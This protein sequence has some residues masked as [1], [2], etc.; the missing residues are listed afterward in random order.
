MY[1]YIKKLEQK[2]ESLQGEIEYFKDAMKEKEDEIWHLET[3]LREV[4]STYNDLFDENEKL[5]SSNYTMDNVI[6]WFNSPFVSD[7]DKAK[8]MEHIKQSTKF[9]LAS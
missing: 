1:E 4:Q 2:N 5:S 7:W 6:E 3:E 8:V 9:N